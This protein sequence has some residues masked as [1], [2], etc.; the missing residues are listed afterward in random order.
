MINEILNLPGY[1]VC[2]YKVV[3]QPNEDLRNRI[4]TLKKDFALKYEA[5]AAEWGQPNITLLTFSQLQL[6]EERF[7]NRLQTIASSLPTFK[8]ELKD[9]GNYP[10]HTI[11]LQVETK[12]PLQI[13]N[14]QLKTARALLRTKEHTPHFLDA[15]FITIAKKLLPWQYEKAWTE[16]NQKHFTAT[17]IAK[18]MLLLRRSEGAKLY[19]IIASFDFLNMPVVTKQGVLF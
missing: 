12:T 2:D 17:F 6:M 9:F 19:N 11:Y 15:F 5:P 16:Y 4:A 13:I 18:N 14:K 8:I 3:L 10:S 7:K 1:K